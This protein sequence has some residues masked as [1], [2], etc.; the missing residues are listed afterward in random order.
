MPALSRLF[1]L[2]AAIAFSLILSACS[3]GGTLSP[4]LT[5][6]MDAPGARLDAV[7]ALGLVNHLRSSRGAQPLTLDANLSATA[8]QAA[9]IYSDTNRSP[10]SPDGAAIMT[11]AGYVT[12]AETFSGW[13]GSAQDAEA[14]SD[15]A[16]RRA[17]LAVTWD[18]GSEYG[19]YWVLLMAP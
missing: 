6:R 9:D 11:S 19:A 17:G 16:M 2:L 8:Q 12:F 10:K 1:A 15:P 5:A 7:T 14:L 18:G 4:G 13:R 3:T